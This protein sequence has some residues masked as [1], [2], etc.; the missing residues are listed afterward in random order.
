[1]KVFWKSFGRAIVLCEVFWV[2]EPALGATSLGM[3][4]VTVR[5]M[6]RYF[7]RDT[8]LYLTLKSLEDC[9]LWNYL[10][11]C[12][13][14]ANHTNYTIKNTKNNIGTALDDRGQEKLEWKQPAQ[15]LYRATFRSYRVCHLIPLLHLGAQRWERI[16]DI[17]L[18]A[19]QRELDLHVHLDT[20]GIRKVRREIRLRSLADSHLALVL[21]M[22]S[23]EQTLSLHLCERRPLS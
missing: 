22:G 1:M 3:P 9:V 12:D 21:W 23:N 7:E 16:D 15:L 6:K 5:C 17:H 2:S 8:E 11:R 19:N 18:G 4:E 14:S 10:K 13:K 20:R